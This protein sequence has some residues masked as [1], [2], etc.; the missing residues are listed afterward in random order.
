MELSTVELLMESHESDSPRQNDR[1][2]FPK[3]K[4]GDIFLSLYDVLFQ[5]L[6]LTWEGV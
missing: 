4:Q 2:F 3:V 5:I 1:P 6:S